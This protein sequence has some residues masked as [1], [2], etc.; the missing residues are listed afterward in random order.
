MSIYE[1]ASIKIMDKKVVNKEQFK[2]L[3]LKEAK[4]YLSE[5][6]GKTEKTEEKVTF[7][8]IESL[9]N[10]MKGMN[11][12]ISSLIEES[13]EGDVEKTEASWV[14]N[15]DRDLDVIE[16]NKKKNITHVN[17]GEKEKWNRMLKYEIP[18]DEER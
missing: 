9:I 1:K 3:V 14:P 13:A 16:H 12:S 15:K 7:D 2:K 17:E 10:E 8:K 11:K 18:T 5:E 4:K 6:E